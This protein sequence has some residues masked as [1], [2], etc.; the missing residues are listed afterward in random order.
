[1]LAALGV[2]FLVLLVAGLIGFLVLVR[3]FDAEPGA[4]ASAPEPPP[5]RSAPELAK[6]EAWLADARVT[7]PRLMLGEGQ[8]LRD[9]RATARE[10]RLTA[11]GKLEVAHLDIDGLVPFSVVGHEV[12]HGVQ[13]TAAPDGLVRITTPVGPFKRGSGR[14]VLA[15]VVA[16]GERLAVTPVRVDGSGA[17]SEAVERLPT[18]RQKIPG[19]PEG[20]RITAVVV[21]R[22]GFRIHAVG[23]DVTLPN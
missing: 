3:P 21:S 8:D 14:S 17:L 15:R 5:A 9:M 12:G 7:S 16:D 22:E 13:F 1:V 11:D 19:L 6:G 18:I 20:T 10:A 2:L 23:E 4:G